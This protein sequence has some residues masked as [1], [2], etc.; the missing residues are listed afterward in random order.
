VPSSYEIVV[1]GAAGPTLFAALP[2]FEERPAPS[3]CVRLVGT[4][5]DQAALQGV[6]H[7]L[8]ELHVELIEVHRLVG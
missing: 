4:V 1:A 5:V 2:D 6:L 8:H 3:G 7:R